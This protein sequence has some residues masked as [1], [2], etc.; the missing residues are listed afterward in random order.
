MLSSRLP[1][2][3]ELFLVPQVTIVRTPQEITELKH[4]WESVCRNGQT[5]IF[6]DFQWNLLAARLF[7]GREEPWLIYAQA[8]YGVAIVPAVMR[9]ADSSLRLLGEELFDYRC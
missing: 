4:V 6:Q 1:T 3:A 9:R 8:S 7:A 2:S 5:T